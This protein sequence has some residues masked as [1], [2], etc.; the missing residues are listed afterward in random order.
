MKSLLEKNGVL[1]F[2]PVYDLTPMRAYSRHNM[3]TLPEMTFGDYGD[4][5]GDSVIS[6]DSAIHRFAKKLKIGKNNVNKT[7]VV[8]SIKITVKLDFPEILFCGTECHIKTP[9]L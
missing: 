6:L 4:F 8:H 9:L 5:I 7:L 2:S 1:D 3:L